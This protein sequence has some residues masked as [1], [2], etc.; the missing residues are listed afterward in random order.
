MKK[1]PAENLEIELNNTERTE[2]YFHNILTSVL[3]NL[4]SSLSFKEFETVVSVFN[5]LG[6]DFKLNLDDP[7]KRKRAMRDLIRLLSELQIYDMPL[8]NSVFSLIEGDFENSREIVSFIIPGLPADAIDKIL[9]YLTQAKSVLKIDFGNKPALQMTEKAPQEKEMDI[10]NWELILKK[11]KEGTASSRDLFQ[12][13]DNEGDK[14]GTISEQEFQVLA[15]R[16]G[17]NLSPHRIKEIFAKIKGPKV[18]ESGEHELNEKEFEIA[19]QYVQDKTLT[20]ALFVLGITPEILTAIFIKLTILLILIFVF[21]FV[22]IKA[23]T[24]GGTFSSIIGSIFT[25]I[26]GLTLGKDKEPEKDKLNP[27]KV[28][29]AADT[30]FDIT[31]TEKL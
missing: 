17:L 16:L 2:L 19:L 31:A 1:N 29:K 15:N 27:K 26:G 4:D 9:T 21:I 23:F 22:G 18:T 11:V 6:S 14:S 13:L 30:A 5:K 24:I 10:T 8:I 20:Q 12:I 25:A 7:Q 28:Q 3:P